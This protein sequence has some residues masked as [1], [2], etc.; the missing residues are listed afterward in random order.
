MKAYTVHAP[1][2]PTGDPVKDAERFEFVCDGFHF[3]AFLFGPF[4]MIWRRMW[5]V[6]LGYVVVT[7]LLQ[8]ALTA[9]GAGQGARFAVAFLLALLVGFEAATL[10]R[11]TLRRRRQ[12]GVVMGRDIEDAERRFFDSWAGRDGALVAAAA[13]PPPA[14]SY[15]PATDVIGLFPEAEPR[16]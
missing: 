9:V 3:W 10:R 12:V 1:R 14:E 16:R 13:A 11:F 6:L 7:V 15:P 5:L 8:L 2:R 4:W